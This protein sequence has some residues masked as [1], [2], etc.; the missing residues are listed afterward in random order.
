M[1]NLKDLREKRGKLVHDARELLERT[2][3]EGRSMTA[4]ESQSWDT[5]MNQAE[6][7]RQEIEREERM[8]EAE[9]ESAARFEREEENGKDVSEEEQRSLAFRKAIIYGPKSLSPEE[10]RSLSYDNSAEGGYLS[11]PEQFVSQLIKAVDDMVFIRSKATT[12]QLKGAH[13]LG[14]PSLEADPADADWTSELAIGTEDGTMSFGKREMVPHP[15]AK[16]IKVSN[17]LLQQSA[18]PAEQI[19]MARLAY[20]FSISEEKAY[21]TGSGASQPLGLFTASSSGISTGRDVSTGNAETSIK[22][23]GLMETKYSLKAQY[24]RTAEWLFH[25]DGVKQIAKLKDGEG[26]YLWQPGITNGS[27][28]MLLGRPVNMSE[29]APNTFTTGQY[30]GMFGDY[31]HYWIV[32]SLAMQMQRLVELYA[33]SNQTGFIGRREL[34]G[35]PVLE[36]AFARVKLA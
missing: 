15:L 4:E 30:V 29:Y 16:F 24:Q 35:A 9:R 10:L 27:S 21:M 36:E 11:P 1:S 13:S 18:M 33:G 12:F 7:V 28:D 22:A 31:S 17:K 20:K 6:D 34:D 25:R 32:D 2:K 23:D 3:K 8:A 5:M 19:V 26:Q 14:A